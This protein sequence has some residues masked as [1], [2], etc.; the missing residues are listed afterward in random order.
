MG[1]DLTL[2][3]KKVFQSKGTN[4][5][6]WVGREREFPKVEARGVAANLRTRDPPALRCSKE[7]MHC[8]LFLMRYI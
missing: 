8:P 2:T 4:P 7:K 1:Y 3:D 6:G 5:A